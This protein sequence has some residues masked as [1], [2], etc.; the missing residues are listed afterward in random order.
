MPLG[1]EVHHWRLEVQHR[2]P[3]LVRARP[4]SA[5]P[6]VASHRLCPA[7]R[8]RWLLRSRQVQI[9]HAALRSTCACTEPRGR[10]PL[11][12]WSAPRSRASLRQSAARIVLLAFLSLLPLVLPV[13]ARRLGAARRR[14]RQLWRRGATAA[15]IGRLGRTVRAS[16]AALA[17]PRGSPMGLAAACRVCKK[18][19]V[20]LRIFSARVCVCAC[21]MRISDAPNSP[22]H[23]GMRSVACNGV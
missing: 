3:L 21:P 23:E 6:R 12:P 9:T 5:S 11:S 13:A 10:P 15:I 4:R 17:R 19:R 8:R 7:E 22:L 16:P 1:D 14:S 2:R 20:S 18:W